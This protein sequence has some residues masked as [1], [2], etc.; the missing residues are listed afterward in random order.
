MYGVPQTSPGGIALKLHA[1]IRLEMS[2]KEPVRAGPQIIG[3][4]VQ[5]RVVK[6]KSAAPFHTTFVNIMYNGEISRLDNLLDLAIELKIINKQGASYSW[7]KSFLGR[8]HETAVS[9][10]RKQPQLAQEIEAAIKKQFLASS[11]ILLDE[12]CK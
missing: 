8:G 4:Q 10:L 11:T 3:E 6:S 2:P 5:V 1:A 12:D 7:S 9:S